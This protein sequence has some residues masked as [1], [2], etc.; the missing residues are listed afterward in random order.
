VL[1]QIGCGFQQFI[2]LTAKLFGVGLIRHGSIMP[3]GGAISDLI[4]GT[5]N[6][7]LLRLAGFCRLRFPSLGPK[8]GFC[9]EALS[10]VLRHGF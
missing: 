5:P 10:L 3:Q 4:R 9:R 1:D 8:R 2:G 6:S 7:A